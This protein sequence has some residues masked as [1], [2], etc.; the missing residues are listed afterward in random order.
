MEKVEPH[1]ENVGIHDA[2]MNELSVYCFA[3]FRERALLG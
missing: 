1:I 2:D 3:K